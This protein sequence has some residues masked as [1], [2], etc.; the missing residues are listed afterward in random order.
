MGQ[1][2]NADGD[3]LEVVSMTFGD[4]KKQLDQEQLMVKRLEFCTI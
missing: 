2:L 3:D 4:L 1:K